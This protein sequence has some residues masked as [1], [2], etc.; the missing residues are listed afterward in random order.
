MGD[1][2]L[3]GFR[4]RRRRLRLR[5]FRGSV[6]L[7]L[8][9]PLP[10]AAERAQHQPRL[11]VLDAVDGGQHA[12]DHIRHVGRI[13]QRQFGHQVRGTGQGDHQLADVQPR[14]LLGHVRHA[15]R[16]AAHPGVQHHPLAHGP[17]VGLGDDPQRVGVHQAADAARDGP[18]GDAGGRTQFAPGR[19]GIRLQGN[20]AGQIG[21]IE[22]WH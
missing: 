14:Q 6:R 20:Q 21:V 9:A 16:P 10:G 11:H 1:H 19:A 22:R 3:F 18:L 8:N 12:R 15:A 17:R 2:A 4:Q 7:G 13:R 5:R